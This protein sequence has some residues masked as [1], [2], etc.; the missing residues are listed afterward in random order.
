MEKAFI[1]PGELTFAK[2]PTN[3]TTVL[4]SCVAI[5][6][7]DRSKK[8]GGMNHFLLPEPTANGETGNKFAEYA[9]KN[10]IKEAIKARCEM[11]NLKAT[12]YGGGEV[13]TTFNQNVSIGQRN[14][15]AAMNLCISMRIPYVIGDVGGEQSRRITMDSTTGQVQVHKVEKSSAAAPKTVLA[16]QGRA[17]VFQKKPRV[18]VVDDSATV[19]KIVRR[20]IEEDG[21]MEV[22]DEAADPFEAREKIIESVPDVISLDIMMPKMNGLEFL[23]RI[24]YFKPIPTV[25]LSTL[26]QE[27]NRLWIDLK[28]AGALSMVNKDDMK[29]YQSSDNLKENLIPKLYLAAKTQVAK[30]NPNL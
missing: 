16:D 22:C 14:I 10:L 17:K 13:I 4:G 28:K 20:A 26:V 24:M 25:V 18:L 12:I 7:W 19:R 30:R 5:C 11:K 6:L 23:K 9:T 29:I 15:Q 3:I 27:G 21:R 2:V 8:M 1:L